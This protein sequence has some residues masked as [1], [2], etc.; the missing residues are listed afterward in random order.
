MLRI[1][2]ENR[3]PPGL[4]LPCS[5]GEDGGDPDPTVEGAHVW[6]SPAVFNGKVYVGKSS[7]LDN[8]CV[9]GAVIALDTATV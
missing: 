8:P 5:Q 4:P 6:S 3:F 7:H 9:R 2:P 1:Y